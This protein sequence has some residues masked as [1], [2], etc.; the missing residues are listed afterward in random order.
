MARDRV[1]TDDLVF[2][3][4]PADAEAL[5]AR[6][7]VVSVLTGNAPV[8]RFCERLDGVAKPERRELGPGGVAVFEVACR[9]PDIAW[10]TA[11]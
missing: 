8:R 9:W 1:E 7:L 4:G 11:D 3:P 6:S 5:G 10:L 2:P